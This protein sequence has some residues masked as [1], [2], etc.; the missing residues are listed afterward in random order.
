MDMCI[1]V[2]LG[3]GCFVV[4]VLGYVLLN[5]FGFRHIIKTRRY[6]SPNRQF[7]SIKLINNKSIVPGLCLI[8]VTKI[9]SLAEMKIL[10]KRCLPNPRNEK[11]EECSIT[12]DFHCTTTLKQW[13][14]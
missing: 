5:H 7:K 8:L 10:Q 9:V 2:G 4:I 3:L 14:D 1:P 6:G 11:I 13:S 12:V